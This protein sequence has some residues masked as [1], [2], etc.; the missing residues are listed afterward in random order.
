MRVIDR[1]TGQRLSADEAY[2][3]FFDGF[4]NLGRPSDIFS[5]TMILAPPRR[6]PVKTRRVARARRRSAVHRAE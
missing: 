6:E 4:Y 2:D 1:I 5:G 3:R